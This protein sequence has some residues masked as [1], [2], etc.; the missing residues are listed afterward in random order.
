MSMGATTP[1][2]DSAR[3]RADPQPRNFC[4]TPRIEA[5][6]SDRRQSMN[7]AP[8]SSHTE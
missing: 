3:G 8:V 2:S 6:I 4:T 5:A 7:D 1:C